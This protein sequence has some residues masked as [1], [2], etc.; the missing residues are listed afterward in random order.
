MVKQPGSTKDDYGV[1]WTLNLAE[2]NDSGTDFNGAYNSELASHKWTLGDSSVSFEGSPAEH[3]K[4]GPP[5]VPEPLGKEGSILFWKSSLVK[6]S[7]LMTNLPQL[8]RVNRRSQSW[9]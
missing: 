9:Y 6:S 4:K 7:I 8:S 2:V 5:F 3:G 1:L